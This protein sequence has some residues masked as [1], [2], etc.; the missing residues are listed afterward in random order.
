MAENDTWEREEDLEY[1]RE[2]VD[3]FK[4]RRDVEVRRHEKVN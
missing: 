1:A 4:G 3:K 2:L